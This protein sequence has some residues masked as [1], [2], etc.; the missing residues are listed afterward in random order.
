MAAVLRR[1]NPLV[2]SL[3]AVGALAVFGGVIGAVVTKAAADRVSNAVPAMQT[4]PVYTYTQYTQHLLVP[5]YA[6]IRVWVLLALLGMIAALTGLF[7]A[8]AARRRA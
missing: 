6:G 1:W 2:V 7:I 3:V 4:L 8:R 5:D